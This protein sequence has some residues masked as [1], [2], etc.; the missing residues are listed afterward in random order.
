LRLRLGEKAGLRHYE[1]L[2]KPIFLGAGELMINQ[3]QTKELFEYRNGILFWKVSPNKKIR[4]GLIAG[5][6]GKY[7]YVN[8]G[9]NRSSYRAHRIIF[10]MH[11]G[12]LPKYLDHINGNRSDNRIENLR[13]CNA[14]E[15]SRNAKLFKT[16]TS[17]VKGLW[18]D[19][20]N[21][22]WKVEL[23]LNSVKLSF[24][25]YSDFELAEL[26]AIEAR[27]KYHG[28]FANHG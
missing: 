27:N 22:K 16:N 11:Y 17:G 19:K 23:R 24:G 28:E 20:L 15:N 8:V 21:N 9:F 2:E 14:S 10:L 1:I 25:R 7:G 18:F 6:L 13:K 4:I 3:A 12:Y 26:V 5:Y